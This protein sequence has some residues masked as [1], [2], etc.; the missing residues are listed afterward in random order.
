MFSTFFSSFTSSASPLECEEQQSRA[1]NET[2]SDTPTDIIDNPED[3]QKHKDELKTKQEEAETPVDEEE[4]EEVEDTKVCKPFLHHLEECGERLAA[5][6]TMVD[7]E[8][9]VEELFHFMHCVDDCAAPKVFA[10]LKYAACIGDLYSSNGLRLPYFGTSHARFPLLGSVLCP[11]QIPMLDVA[12][13]GPLSSGSNPA[14]IVLSDSLLQPSLLVTR[15]FIASALSTSFTTSQ[16]PPVVV[17]IAADHSPVKLLPPT[18]SYDPQRVAVIDCSLPS[19][20][21][22]PPI[23]STSTVTPHGVIYT[24]VD[25]SAPSASIELEAATLQTIEQLAGGPEGNTPVL[26]VLDGVDQMAEEW[27]NGVGQAGKLVRKV[28]A[29]LKGRKGSRLIITHHSDLPAP[30]PSIAS[31]C[32]LSLAQPSILKTL[33]SP[34]LSAATLHLQLRPSSHLETLARDYG[35]T[36]PVSLATEETEEEE[37]LDL[38]LSQF[39]ASLASR[40]VGDPLRRPK[41]AGEEDERVPLDV[42][43]AGAAASTSPSSSS[44]STAGLGRPTV[45]SRA[46]GRGGGCIIEY[47][48]RG[49]DPSPKSSSTPSSALAAKQER[50]K[51]RERSARGEVKKAVRYGFCGVKAGSGQ[52]GLVEV[53]ECR[54]GEVIDGARCGRRKAA[55]VS[56]ELSLPPLTRLSRRQLRL[57]MVGNEPALT[58]VYSH[59]Q[60]SP[61]LT[62]PT[63][64]QSWQQPSSSSASSSRP[65]SSALPFSLSLTPSQLSARASI[66]N[67]FA[68]ASGVIYGEQGFVAVQVPGLERPEGAGTGGGAGRVEYTPDEGDDWDD[69]DPDEDLEI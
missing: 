21:L 24:S 61:A 48:A 8:T 28:L 33:L 22:Y 54:I 42:L 20:S 18:A 25:L 17:L 35:L 32:S 55:E 58:I 12:L 67:P 60:L 45:L 47:S 7:N 16:Q 38:R 56:D 57:K 50:D 41:T 52:D 13:Q 62:P 3:A 68:N 37:D 64:S 63:A 26:V 66:A 51:E 29:A 34:S 46:G 4:E 2:R 1:H 65:A 59:W 36:V 11:A 6:K 53:R 31:S 5:G 43:G 10:A 19:P 40:A 69:E 15:Q 23:A 39:L 44:S 9:C 49:I 14:L 27:E 30:P